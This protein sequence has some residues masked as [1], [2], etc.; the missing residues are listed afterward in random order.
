M[1]LGS[2]HGG[3]GPGAQADV[4]G[5]TCNAWKL[6]DVSLEGIGALMIEIYVNWEYLRTRSVADSF[7]ECGLNYYFSFAAQF[8][9]AISNDDVA[10]LSFDLTNN[11]I[12]CAYISDVL[13]S[14]GNNIVAMLRT[15]VAMLPNHLNCQVLSQDWVTVAYKTVTTEKG[16]TL[17]EFHFQTRVIYGPRF[18][19]PRLNTK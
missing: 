2:T 19:R 13:A 17:Y 14:F 7:K 12:S 6:G 18:N 5:D 15:K 4:Y 8:Y 11:Y 3:Q 10:L 9:S 1:I 16:L